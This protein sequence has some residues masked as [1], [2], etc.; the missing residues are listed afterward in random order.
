[1]TVGVVSAKVKIC[2]DVELV[3]NNKQCMKKRYLESL[4]SICWV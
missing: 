4:G 2:I 3:N 1:M